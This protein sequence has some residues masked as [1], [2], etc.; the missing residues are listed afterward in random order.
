MYLKACIYG[1]TGNLVEFKLSDMGSR[2]STKAGLKA[3]F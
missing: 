2:Y 3:A 1:S